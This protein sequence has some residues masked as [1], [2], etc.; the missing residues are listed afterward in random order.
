MKF[1]NTSKIQLGVSCKK[2]YFFTLFRNAWCKKCLM[3]Y[4]NIRQNQVKNVPNVRTVHYIFMFP[5]ENT[6]RK[7]TYG[8]WGEEDNFDPSQIGCSHFTHGQ[9]QGDGQ[10]CISDVITMVQIIA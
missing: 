6:F 2:V 10:T 9:G 8:N 1:N 5:K 4:V 7:Y 3:D